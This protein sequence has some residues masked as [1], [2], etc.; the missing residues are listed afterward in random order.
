MTTSEPTKNGRLAAAFSSLRR[1]SREINTTLD[2]QRILDVVLQASLSLADASYGVIL[3][4]EAEGRSFDLRVTAGYSERE[5]TDVR[6]ALQHPVAH[7]V[8]RDVLSTERGRRFPLPTVG[9]RERVPVPEGGRDD[10]GDGSRSGL[11]RAERALGVEDRPWFA[12]DARTMMVVPIF[13]AQLLTGLII[14]E[15]EERGAFDRQLMRFVEGLAD[16]AAIAIGNAR[17]YQEQLER[18]EMLRRRAEQLASVLEVARALR[19]D[20][21]LEDILEEVAYGIQETVGFDLVLV[22]V[23]EGDPP[24]QRRVAA[25]GIPLP[26]FERIREVRQPWSLIERLMDERF[27]ISQSFYIPAERRPAWFHQL[28]TYGVEESDRSGEGDVR[29][30][31]GAWHPRDTLIVPLVGPG[32]DVK[33]VV[34]LDEP[35]DGQVPDRTT[36]ETVEVFAAQAA[37]AIENAQMVEMLQRRAEVLSLFNEISQSATAKLALDE[38]LEDVVETAPRLLP[39]DHSSIFLLDPEEGRYTPRAVHGSP[40]ESIARSDSE[41]L[42]FLPGEGLVGD[43]VESGLP[44]TIDVADRRRGSLIGPGMTMRTAVLT[45]LTVG[46]QVVG[47]LCVARRSDDDFSAAEVAML[48]ALADQVSVAIDNARLFEEVHSFSQ[49]LEQ[50]VEERTAELAAAMEELAEERDQ[51]E[52]LYRITSQLSASLDLDHVLSKAMASILEAVGADRATTLLVDDESRRLIARAA[53]GDDVDLPPGG[54]PTR[55]AL[56]EGLAG[57]VMKHRTAALVPNLQEDDRWVESEDGEDQSKTAR[58]RAALAAPLVVSGQVLGAILLLDR[59]VGYFHEEHL[60][61]LRAVAAQVAQAINNAEL[62][63]VIRQQAERLGNM[64]KAQQIES[65]KSQA[66]LEG[67]ADGVMVTDAD[68]KVVLFNAAAERILDL[69][70]EEAMGRTTRDMLGLYGS[71]AQDW[72]ETVTEWAERPESYDRDDYLAAQLEIED[73]VVSVHLA[74]VLM[75]AQ[76][77]LPEFLGTVS[78]FRDVT[79]EVEA[80]RA[81]TEFVSMVSHELRTPMTSIKGY[82]DLLLMESVGPLTD[83][84]EKFLSIVRSNV[85]RLTTLVDDLLDISRIESGRLELAARRMR[86][87]EAVDRVLASMEA[88]ANEGGVLLESQ[89]PP[90]LSMVHADP[91]RVAQILTN[92]VG[93]ACQYTP[94]GGEVIVSAEEKGGMV[95]VMVRDTGIGISPQDQGRVFDRFFRADS[96][97]VQGTPGTGLGLPIVKSLV[98]MHGGEI[99]VESEL[100]QGS[101]FTFTLPTG[102]AGRPLAPPK[103]PSQILV[104]EDDL[105]IAKLI[106][107]HLSGNG[108]QVRV[109][110]QG[111]E[112]LALAREERPDLITLDVMLPD[113]NGFEL[114]ETLKSDPQTRDIPVVIV[115]VV[116]DRQEGLRLGAADYVAKPIDEEK[117]LAAVRKALRRTSGTVLVVEDDRDTL[118]LLDDVLQASGFAVRMVTREGDP[119]A[120]AREVKPCLILLDVELPDLDGYAVLEQLKTDSELGDVPVIVMTGSEIIDDAQ[121]R[122]VL[123]LGAERFVAKPFSIEELVEQIESAVA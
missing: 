6:E 93:N 64:L 8:L 90:D 89:L 92:L 31:P 121:R 95:H 42:A 53:V 39:C 105:H 87:E 49:E 77:S 4:R 69:P 70:R 33:G 99:W 118:S 23:A 16:Q 103:G 54:R 2:L 66:I 109:A 35:R 19:S 82:A 113:V 104:V 120:A 14:L 112:A 41:P 63:N 62:Y 72:L 10:G 29:R 108:R 78:V 7:P 123:A 65:T 84:Q 43:V 12:R 17:R 37:V 59:S 34:S 117:L 56:G 97:E 47:V 36:I 88:R 85:D 58:P 79:A 74:P 28:D 114:L 86:V 71:Q 27:R 57:W 96:P 107:F 122:E 116:A 101:R 67:V 51:V 100:G 9:S 94:R 38:V 48:S 1:V 46:Q 13:Y 110:R 22:S 15:N 60:R 81:K 50:R 76:R 24:I 68:G 32:S 115:S 21:P 44:L 26:T 25:A 5:A 20:R 40:L 98:A 80:D 55:F 52:A 106:Q 30:E 91:D 83:G 119:L 45:P 3:V 11:P 102:E 61:L 18:G 75:G 111:D 73:R